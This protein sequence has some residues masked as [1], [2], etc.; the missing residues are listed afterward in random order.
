MGIGL[1]NL[2]TLYGGGCEIFILIVSGCR[3]EPM[4]SSLCPWKNSLSPPGN[5][6]VLTF[7]F[8]DDGFDDP[9]TFSNSGVG[10]ST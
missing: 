8:L 6:F 1:G 10:V 2:A 5:T 7:A 4:F 3:N 9:I